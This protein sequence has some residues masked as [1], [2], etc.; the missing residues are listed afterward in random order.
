MVIRTAECPDIYPDISN[1]PEG[2]TSTHTIFRNGQFIIQIPVLST[3]SFPVLDSLWG[4]YGFSRTPGN[5][6]TLQF[7]YVRLGSYVSQL[8]AFRKFQFY[9]TTAWTKK[10]FRKI[11]NCNQNN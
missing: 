7:S 3:Q 1:L 8:G 4:S 2:L 5:N 9:Y 11:R 10:D 6:G